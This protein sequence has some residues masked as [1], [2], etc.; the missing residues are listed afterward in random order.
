MTK[1]NEAATAVGYK[2]RSMANV[3]RENAPH[4]GAVASVA[5]AVVVG[6]DSASSYLKEKNLTIY[7]RTSLR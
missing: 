5:T 6:L 2:I 3:I 4:D 7:Q 1:A